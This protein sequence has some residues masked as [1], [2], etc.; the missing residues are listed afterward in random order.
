MPSEKTDQ[1]AVKTKKYETLYIL[2]ITL[3]TEE[4]KAVMKKVNDIITKHDGSIIKEENLGKRK[5][6]YML[7]RARHGSYALT[8]FSAPIDQANKINRELELM[9]EILRHQ[10]S[11]KED[12]KKPRID[13]S[14]IISSDDK[15][16]KPLK[17]TTKD[18]KFKDEKV[19]TQELDRKLDE[20][21]TEHDV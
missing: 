21:L 20:L 4:V 10:L 7:K 9:P 13:L 5:L 12:I 14:K 6:A 16:T 3:E 8:V 17:D 2:P 18:D 1:T 19:D 15:T 11:I